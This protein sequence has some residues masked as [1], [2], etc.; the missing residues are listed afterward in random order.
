MQETPSQLNR[1][2]P[3]FGRVVQ[4][5]QKRRLTITTRNAMTWSRRQSCVGGVVRG[6]GD[7]RPEPTVAYVCP[8]NVTYSDTMLA[9]QAP[10]SP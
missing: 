8:P 7:Q 3:L 10:P 1:A 5:R 4:P 9:F 6:V 2:V